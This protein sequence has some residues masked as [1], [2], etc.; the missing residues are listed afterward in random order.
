MKIKIFKGK[1]SAAIIQPSIYLNKLPTIRVF[2]RLFLITRNSSE[3]EIANVNCLYDDIVEYIM[4]LPIRLVINTNLAP[5]LHRFRDIAFD[6]SKI[7]IFGYP[8]CV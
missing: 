1:G 8:S 7:A 2:R 6:R 5:I 4:Q 3:D